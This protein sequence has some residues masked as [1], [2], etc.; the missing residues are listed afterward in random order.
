[1]A[2]LHL[3]PHRN[4]KRL[5]HGIDGCTQTVKKVSIIIL[6]YPLL[7]RRKTHQLNCKLFNTFSN[8]PKI[9]IYI[10]IY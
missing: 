8:P 10:Y 2:V 5:L 9:Y 4:R 1:M 7:D 6:V 3:C